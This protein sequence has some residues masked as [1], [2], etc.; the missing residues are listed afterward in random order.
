MQRLYS[1]DVKD[2]ERPPSGADEKSTER[3]AKLTI[4]YNVCHYRAQPP[5]TSVPIQDPYEMPWE[6]K[7]SLLGPNQV[8]QMGITRLMDWQRYGSTIW[9]GVGVF[10]VDAKK[11]R[12]FQANQPGAAQ[13][14]GW[15]GKIE[16][17]LKGFFVDMRETLR[18]EGIP[19][20]VGI[21]KTLYSDV[22]QKLTS[23]DD[24]GK[25]IEVIALH[26]DK[27]K[28]M[29][30]TANS[31]TNPNYLHNFGND[32]IININECEKNIGHLLDDSQLYVLPYIPYPSSMTDPEQIAQ[33]RRSVRDHLIKHLG[34]GDKLVEVL[35]GF[36]DCPVPLEGHT[37][38]LYSAEEIAALSAFQAALAKDKKKSEIL[39]KLLVGRNLGRDFPGV[40]S[41]YNVKSP[42]V[43]LGFDFLLYMV[44]RRPE[45]EPRP[46]KKWTHRGR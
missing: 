24:D 22:Y 4:S 21:V 15:S 28:G 37:N 41:K 14:E 7:A 40:L 42:T 18:H 3:E 39:P 25:K 32:E 20:D 16:T 29:G 35:L 33:Y 6:L 9:R 27:F 1:V 19:V 12:S 34:S 45:D 2:Y 30:R 23:E 8:S 43:M 17:Y 5:D 46:L 13:A 31:A 10:H 26:L 36:K 38:L 11:T 44:Q